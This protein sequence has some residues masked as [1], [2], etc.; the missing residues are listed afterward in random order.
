MCEGDLTT[1]LCD[2]VWVALAGLWGN[3]LPSNRRPKIGTTVLPGTWYHL[4]GTIVDEMDMEIYVDGQND[5]GVLDGTG[6]GS[7]A[8]T[9][10]S[11]NRPE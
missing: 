5:G 11:A 10:G 3:T 7:V 8:H 2:G 9:T 6:P 4:V 1:A